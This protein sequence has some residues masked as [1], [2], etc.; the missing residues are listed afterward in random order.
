MIQKNLLFPE[1]FHKVLFCIKGAV[2]ISNYIHRPNFKRIPLIVNHRIS[3]KKERAKKTKKEAK[4]TNH[5]KKPKE[6]GPLK[7]PLIDEKV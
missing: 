6:K 7:S 3:H 4:R 1:F 2:I 5:Y